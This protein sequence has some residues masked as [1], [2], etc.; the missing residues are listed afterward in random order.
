M[1]NGVIDYDW[2]MGLD[3]KSFFNDT[4]ALKRCILDEKSDIMK[5]DLISRPVDP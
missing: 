4:F 1:I 5:Y 3:S 2:S